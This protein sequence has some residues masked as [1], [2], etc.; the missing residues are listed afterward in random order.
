MEMQQTS[1]TLPGE[2]LAEIN[3]A[4]G[5]INL[6]AFIVEMTKAELIRRRRSIG[7][8]WAGAKKSVEPQPG[9]SAWMKV[10]REEGEARLTLR[11]F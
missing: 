6:T 9:T 4:V 3:Q 8:G 10:I 5:P 11:H 1:I 2:L 7:P